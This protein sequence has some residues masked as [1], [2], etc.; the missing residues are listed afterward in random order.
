MTPEA[1]DTQSIV[2]IL[3]PA[4]YENLLLNRIF[5]QAFE[6]ALV[7]EAEYHELRM[8]L[9]SFSIYSVVCQKMRKSSCLIDIEGCSGSEGLIWALKLRE[10]SLI[11]Q[12]PIFRLPS[13]YVPLMRHLERRS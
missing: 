1:I 8:R 5:S 13:L 12:N 4:I 3:F 7:V 9:N 2:C 11:S 10:L 6:F